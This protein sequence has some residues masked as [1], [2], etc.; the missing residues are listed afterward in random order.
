MR[1]SLKELLLEQVAV[2]PLIAPVNHLLVLIKVNFMG[3]VASIAAVLHDKAERLST[4]G[5]K[6]EELVYANVKVQ[7]IF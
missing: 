3:Y 5:H 1:A 2:K 6:R 4:F 7:A